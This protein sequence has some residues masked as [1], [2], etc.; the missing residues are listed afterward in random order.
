[1]PGA[2]SAQGVRTAHGTQVRPLIEACPLGC[3][4][5]LRPTPI[6]LPEGPL[7]QCPACT[8]LVS[9]A[10]QA[11]HA[12]SLAIWDTGEGTQP[13][14]RSVERFRTVTRRRLAMAQHLLGPQSAARLLDVGCSSGSLL[15]VAAEMGF[16][17]RGVESAPTAAAAA[18]RAGFDVHDGRLQDAGYAPGSFD[19]ITLIELIEHI[20]EPL[21]L[22]RQCRDLLR[23]G[24]V[25][26]I[27]T[28]NGAS[29]SA[30]ALG[31]KWEGF[32]LTKL[33]GHV[34]FYSP[35]ALQVLAERTGFDV[36]AIR[37]RHL[38][39]TEADSTPQ[40]IHRIVKLISKPAALAARWLGTGHDML[41]LLQ[42][43]P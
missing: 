38:R 34:C 23:P 27:N 20:A 33:G 40:P 10:T 29:W 26:A 15:A 11:Q 19:V 39:L 6:V 28:P 18:R 17:V 31:G 43:R 13:D 22:L 25:V 35:S 2:E 12:A 4:G 1:M 24:G 37:T 41:A 14:A 36:A 32:S 9:S 8:L 7:R 30:R 16:A 3:S 21:P 42:R 5:E